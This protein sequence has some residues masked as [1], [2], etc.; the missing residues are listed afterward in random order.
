MNNEELHN[1]YYSSNIM[2]DAHTAGVGASRE[3]ITGR[4]RCRLK[5]IRINVTRAGY[6]RERGYIYKD[7]YPVLVDKIIRLR[8]PYMGN[9][10]TA[11]GTVNFSRR[12]LCSVKLESCRDLK[13][14]DAAS[15]P[16]SK[17]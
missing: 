8:V 5:D 10:L 9:F 4:H 11:R 13:I 17:P 12:S 1:F 7:H 6:K 2:G 16:R 14:L 15:V 3:Q